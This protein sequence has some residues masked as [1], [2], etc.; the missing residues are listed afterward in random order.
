M[1]GDSVSPVSAAGLELLVG[2]C[3]G[4]LGAELDTDTGVVVVLATGGDL[5]WLSCIE[6]SLSLLDEPLELPE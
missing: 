5:C 3:D 4:D 2:S 6:S 1:V